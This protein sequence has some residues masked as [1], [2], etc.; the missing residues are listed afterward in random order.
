MIADGAPPSNKDQGY[1]TRRLLRRSIRYA[2]KIGVSD[3]FCRPVGEAVIETYKDAYPNLLK[4]R[5]HILL[6]LTIEE[7]KFRK[8]LA[9]GLKEAELILLNSLETR[10]P[11]EEETSSN[12]ADRYVDELIEKGIFQERM[13]INE[14]VPK[15]IIGEILFRTALFTGILETKEEFNQLI[16]A[17]VEPTSDFYNRAEACKAVIYSAGVPNKTQPLPPFVDINEHTYLKDYIAT[18]YNLSLTAGYRENGILTK[19]FEPAKEITFGELAELL[20]NALHPVDAAS[21]FKLYDTYG[22]PMEL[23]QELAAEKGKFVRENDFKEAFKKHQELSRSGMEKKFKGGLVDHSSA[24]VKYHTAT[25]LMHTALRTILGTHVEQ[26]GSNITPERMRFDFSHP[27]KMTPEEIQKVEDLVND[28]I[29][30]E[31][32]V[33]YSFMTVDEALANG[34]IG[35]FES[36]YASYG[37]KVKVYTMGN[38]CVEICGGPHVINTKH[39]KKFKILKEE[40]VAAGIRRIKAVVEDA[41]VD[42]D[43][44]PEKAAS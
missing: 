8:T 9:K 21:A 15:L 3:N 42:C 24:S 20:S 2:Y 38:F 30:L 33:W 4:E 12:W 40:A 39:L 17:R 43:V 34:A 7:E 1:F 6:E 32:P 5:D 10:E 25:H 41:Q 27:A 26:R 14:R 37:D 18:A 22:F 31:L 19:S 29:R 28:Q 35:L 16:L 44:A 36:K 23:T 11:S 13:N